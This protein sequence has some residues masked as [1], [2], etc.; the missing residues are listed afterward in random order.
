MKK[1]VIL[2]FAC[3]MIVMLFAGSLHCYATEVEAGD[4]QPDVADVGADAVID[5]NVVAE[6]TI[7]EETK[8]TVEP[9][10]YHTLYSRVLEYYNANKTEIIGLAGNGIL[11]GVLLIVRSLFKKKIR[12]ISADIK[13]VKG[14]AA[15]TASAQSSVVGAVNS[16]IDGYN[17]MRTAYE[18][19]ELTEDDRNKLVGAVMVQNTAILEIL[20]LVYVH[21]KNIPQGVKDLVTLKY[22]NC[23]KSLEDDELLRAV[24]DSVREKISS[25]QF[26][27]EAL[28]EIESAGVKEKT[29]E[30]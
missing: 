24:V 29:V 7:G 25:V 28:D 23:Q 4:A 3:I 21:N 27:P 10:A 30:A 17:D 26:Q 18:K 8:P 9:S 16:M 14:D 12:E 5:E 1:R 6:T 15:G 22:A 20:S 2:I 13:I 19:Y 11:L